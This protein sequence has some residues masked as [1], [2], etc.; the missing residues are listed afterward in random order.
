MSIQA[1]SLLK[2]HFGYDSF[3]PMQS[4][5]I[6]SILDKKDSVV[7]MPTGGGKSICFQ[8]PALM[9]P[10]LCIVVSPLIS[11][12]KDQVDTLNANG[13]AAQFLNSS[14]DFQAQNTII[15]KCSNNEI[16]ILYLSPERVN[17][18]ID[19]LLKKLPVSLFAID[20]AH[21]VS[22]WGHDFRPEYTKLG[23]LKTNFPN[24]PLIALTATANLQTQTDI[25][26]QLNLVNPDV[27]I[28]SF[29][30]PN[31]SI[32]VRPEVNLKQRVEEIIAFVKTRSQEIGI[33]YCLSRNK[34]DDL[35]QTLRTNGINAASYHAGL[36]ASERYNVQ[37]QFIQDKVHVV[38]AT[39][40]FGMGIDKSNVRYVIHF[41]PPKSIEGYCQ[42][43]GRAG[44]DG[45]ASDTIMYFSYADF[46]IL[47][48]FGNNQSQSNLEKLRQVKNFAKANVCRRKILLTYFGEAPQ[49]NCGN[50]DI[51]NPR[52]AI[53][54]TK[55]AIL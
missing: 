12:M 54:I 52:Q 24:V 1:L 25:I 28:A 45:L 34:C 31:L 36:L 42:E 10:G 51:C 7:L 29:D 15:Q 19:G 13:I 17:K 14:L 18:D 6:Q 30:R 20:E 4:Q 41:N 47:S 26:K 3:R 2:Q 9:L 35:A 53:N 21:C 38:C 37:D 32:T 5:I 27:F 48:S 43:I 22:S 40:A 50:C 49:S 55:I 33:I 16:K 8:I 11:L 44:R 46:K 39:I 23:S